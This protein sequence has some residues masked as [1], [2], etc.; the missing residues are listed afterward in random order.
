MFP[1]SLKV[2]VPSNISHGSEAVPTAEEDKL[3]DCLTY[4]DIHKFIGP[5]EMHLRLLKDVA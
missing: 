3:R 2:V 5:C 1:S 4:L